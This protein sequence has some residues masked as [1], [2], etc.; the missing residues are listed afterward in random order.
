ME[1]AELVEV[2]IEELKAL[3]QKVNGSDEL[4]EKFNELIR[5]AEETENPFDNEE[6]I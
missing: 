1:K 6:D 5:L 3:L 2:S 4:V